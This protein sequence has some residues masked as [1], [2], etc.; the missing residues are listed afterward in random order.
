MAIDN[1]KALSLQ[2]VPITEALNYASID[3]YDDGQVLRQ[4]FNNWALR[5]YRKLKLNLLRRVKTVLIKVSPGTQTIKYPDDYSRYSEV[6]Y[7]DGCGNYELMDKV[8]LVEVDNPKVQCSCVACLS[9][10]LCDAVS[11][12][13]TE[14]IISINGVDYTKTTIRQLDK[15]SQSYM[16]EVTEP[17]WDETDLQVVMRTHSKS[18]CDL[19]LLPCGCVAPTEEN[20]TALKNCCCCGLYH[21]YSS[22]SPCSSSDS[23]ATDDENRVMHIF[24]SMAQVIRLTYVADVP[25]VNGRVYVPEISLECI[26]SWILFKRDERRNIAVVQKQFSY[27][28][29]KQERS[30]LRKNII[31]IRASVIRNALNLIPY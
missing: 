11:Y 24:A 17:F 2:W 22:C 14:E 18:L 8:S 31:P 12:D 30:E 4:R 20:I 26:A 6:G 25:M 9:H 13:K 29:Y 3:D 27:L 19:E 5:G 10:G 15:A 7:Y 21:Y 1:Q 28:R 23:F 16:E